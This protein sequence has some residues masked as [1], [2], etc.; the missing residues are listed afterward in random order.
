MEDFLIRDTCKICLYSHETKNYVMSDSF[1]KIVANSAH[2]FLISDYEAKKN[3][4]FHIQIVHPGKF[5]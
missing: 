3:V 4:V 2:P 5:I 1:E